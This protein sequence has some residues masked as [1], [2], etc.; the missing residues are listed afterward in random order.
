MDRLSP[1]LPRALALLAAL[2]LSLSACGKGGNS[3][4]GP[5]R[6]FPNA[7]PEAPV[8]LTADAPAAWTSS[9]AL[10]VHDDT[11]YVADDLNGAL[12]VLDRA[13]LTIRRTVPVGARPSHVAVGP[14]GAAW[15]AV[16][17]AG[18]VVRVDPGATSPSLSVTVGGEPFGIVLSPEAD[19]VYV[20]DHAGGRLITLDAVTGQLLAASPVGRLLRGMAVLGEAATQRSLLVVQQSGPA[21]Q[22]PLESADGLPRPEF[23]AASSLRRALPSDAIFNPSRAAG[24]VA[25]RAMAA[26]ALPGKSAGLVVHL[27]AETGTSDEALEVAARERFDEVEVSDGYGSSTRS[28]SGFQF[29]V[30]SRPVDAMVSRVS[31]SADSD[32]GAAKL[33]VVSPVSGEPMTARLAQPSDANHHPTMSLV[34]VTGEGSDNVVVFNTASSDAD[35]IAHPVAEI[36]VGMAPRA[37]AFAADGTKAYV[38]NGHTLTVGE[39]DLSKLL[40]MEPVDQRTVAFGDD[41]DAPPS[42]FFGGSSDSG[43]AIPPSPQADPASP[44]F[45]EFQEMPEA[46]RVSTPPASTRF[47]HPL[48]LR[49]AREASYGVDPSPEA[50][51]RGRRV[52][53]NARNSRLSKEGQFACAT[54]H[55]DGTEDGLVWFIK[56]GP[57]QTIALA[58]RLADTA[59]FNWIGTKGELQN[60]MEQTIARMGGHGLNGSELADLEQY[61]LH[62]LQAPRSPYLAATGLDAQQQLGKQI[63]EDP[64]VGCSSCHLGEAFTDG[65]LYDVGATTDVEFRLGQ[66]A[67]DPDGEQPEIGLFNTPSLRGLWYSA[68]YLHNGRADT[69]YDALELTAGKMGATAHLDSTEIDAL[70]AYLLTL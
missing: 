24:L 61:L 26:T 30:P 46:P 13:T 41:H 59:P 39:I 70:V 6:E 43:F 47:V 49:Q 69:L 37:I 32:A 38:L 50:V 63:F 22:I 18:T 51:R 2:T 5:Q 29:G 16:R 45:E 42:A 10:A 9:R 7:L 20:S 54:C 19:R 27:L 34:F 68:P 4:A 48:A 21:L 40:A 12:V 53:M 65:N 14:D 36:A 15:V 64:E 35:P 57:R 56:D 62:G 58:G 52:F 28:E 44:E 1:T 3:Q 67:M 17:G 25:S 11:L 31:P 8:A 33:P 55:P 60:N 23:A 66:M